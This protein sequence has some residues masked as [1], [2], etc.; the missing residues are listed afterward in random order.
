ML[1]RLRG[2]LSPDKGPAARRESAGAPQD[3]PPGLPRY[4]WP[5]EAPEAPA[6]WEAGPPS[7]VGVGAQRAGTSW[8]YRFALDSHPGVAR[9][10]SQRKE[11]HFFDR[12]WTDEVP[13]DLGE[14][15]ARM[16]PRPAGAMA[17]EWTP[18]YMHDP[19]TPPLLREAAPD[20][21]LLVMLRDPVDR[22]LSGIAR[23]VRLANR[24]G[25]PL[26]MAFVSD[27]IARSQYLK[28]LEA[29][30]AHFPAEQVLVLQYE[31]CAADPVAE[32]ARTCDFLGLDQPAAHPPELTTR[33]RAPAEKPELPDGLRHGLSE[34]LRPDAEAVVS[35]CP[36]LDP[37]LWPTL[38]STA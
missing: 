19:W 14:K 34:W 1:R 4:L 16:F 7:F 20:A 38:G 6:G 10:Q 35:L 3:G 15:Y 13:T 8:W 17:G 23:E 21:R 18:R 33:R 5:T 24:D 25:R 12:F 26:A 27:Q 31:R 29:L 30:F 2:Y 36:D 32:R 37:S 11:L 28:A 9:A 22:Y